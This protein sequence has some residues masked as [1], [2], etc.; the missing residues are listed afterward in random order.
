MRR[1]L[2]GDSEPHIRLL[3]R[4][5]LEEEGYEVQVAGS[6]GEIVRLAESFKPHL[7]IM[8]VLL[9]DMS[10]LEAGRMVKGTTKETRII[11]FS[12]GHP[13][14][15]LSAWGGDAYV[16]KTSDLEPL[17]KTVRYLCELNSSRH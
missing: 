9:P 17:K 2:F 13:P 7:V 12:H 6:G 4:E 3:C 11:Y 1:I 15:D 16:L 8:E 14:K 5:E 10:G